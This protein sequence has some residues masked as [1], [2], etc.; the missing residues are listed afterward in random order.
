MPPGRPVS[1]SVSLC[2]GRVYLVSHAHVVIAMLLC[3]QKLFLDTPCCACCQTYPTAICMQAQHE[4][5]A[6]D[7]W[8][9]EDAQH[10][11]ERHS[12]REPNKTSANRSTSAGGPGEGTGQDDV[13]LD[14]TP[15]QHATAV[16]T[17]QHTPPDAADL[18]SSQAAATTDQVTGAHDTGALDATIPREQRPSVQAIQL[19]T[20]AAALIRRSVGMR[21]C[22]VTPA[23]VRAHT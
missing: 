21:D 4:K 10:A 19:A 17:S 9:S 13:A 5:A 8:D 2:T 14:L 23:E 3:T 18:A 15:R 7:A 12:P 1:S 11:P 6:Q 20:R 16:R 22:M